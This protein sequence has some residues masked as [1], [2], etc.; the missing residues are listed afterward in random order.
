MFVVCFVFVFVLFVFVV[1]F[2]FWFFFFVVWLGAH[3]GLILI[4]PV[5]EILSIE[6]LMNDTFSLPY[7]VAVAV[8]VVVAVAAA[9]QSQGTGLVGGSQSSRMEGLCTKTVE[10]TES[11]PLA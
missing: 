3:C 8:D 5:Y 9:A 6:L 7:V 11:R 1:V 2:F 10:P 4:Q